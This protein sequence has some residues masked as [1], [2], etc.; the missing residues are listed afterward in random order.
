[1]QPYVSEPGPPGTRFA[2]IRRFEVL[3]STNRYLADEAVAG[4]PEGLVAVTDFQSAGR[5]RL[6][7][8]WEAPAGTNL[9]A[10]VLFRPLLDPKDLHLLTVVVAL[11]TADACMEAA[12]LEPHL[13]WP[14]DLYVGKRKLAGVL[15]ESVPERA[16]SSPSMSPPGPTGAGGGEDG[17]HGQGT[18]Q[19]RAVVVGLG[20]NVRW[21]QPDSVSPPIPVPDEFAD[22][23]T[24]LW[25]ESSPTRAE[26]LDCRVILDLVLAALEHRVE[27]LAH[28][29]GRRRQAA[30]YRRRCSTVGRRVKVTLGD[31]AFEATAVDVT[32]EGHLVVESDSTFRTI[33]AGDVVHLD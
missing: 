32:D 10:S 25:R 8:R 21:P 18:G 30:E 4:A 20:L 3:D 27:N 29:D 14:N 11:A 6:G 17:G 28:G 12:G 33:T 9:L 16:S 5:G 15:A 2:E 7:R 26:H 19:L 13:E 1:M 23:A 31:S 24:S 22:I